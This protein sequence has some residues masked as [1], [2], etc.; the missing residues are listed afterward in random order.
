[1]D[2]NDCTVCEGRVAK[3]FLITGVGGKRLWAGDC[4]FLRAECSMHCEFVFH[5]FGIM[6]GAAG[7]GHILVVNVLDM[8]LDTSYVLDL[9]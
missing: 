5:G 9:G 3:T 4:F 1:M 7:Y 8:S 2:G 6:D